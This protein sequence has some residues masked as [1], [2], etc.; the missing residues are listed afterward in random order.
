MARIKVA[1]SARSDAREEPA[2]QGSRF[3]DVWGAVTAD[4]Y[5]TLPDA[6]L[7]PLSAL[8]LLR[9]G[10]FGD[11]QRTLAQKSDLLPHFDKLVHP[12]G[13]C[14]SGRWRIGARTPYTGLFRTGSEG[15]VIARASDALGEQRPHRLRFMGL[16]GKLYPT[17]D[18]EHAEPLP[19]ASFFTLENLGGSHTQRFVDAT[20]STDLLPLRPHGGLVTKLALGAV[21][22]SAFMLADRALGP[23]Q[24]MIRTLAPIA[25]LGEPAGA[26]VRAPTV[27]RLVASPFNRRIDTPDL[28]EELAIAHHPEG[29]RFDIQVADRRSYAF[30]TGFRTIGVIHFDASVA[31]H[32]GDHRLHF[33][34]PR[35]GER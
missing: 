19:T 11:A 33:H 23:S 27:M 20:L 8:R 7:R 25:G 2:Y 24:A 16:A 26:E 9:D 31:S 5:G 15:L 21:V 29:L 14:L 10:I 22:G 13:V 35:P 6:R 18:P 30:A 34:H 12:S 3:A 32:G 28:R 4:P 1:A 17:R